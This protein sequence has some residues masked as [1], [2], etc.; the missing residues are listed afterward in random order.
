MHIND[1]AL[2]SSAPIRTPKKVSASYEKKDI[3][4]SNK[5]KAQKKNTLNSSDGWV[6]LASTVCILSVFGITIFG[7]YLW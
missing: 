3:W 4:N 7:I 6:L 1:E 5:K 2:V